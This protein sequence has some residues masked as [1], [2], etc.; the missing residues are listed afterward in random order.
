MRSKPRTS[1]LIV[2]A[3]KPTPTPM[4]IQTSPIRYGSAAHFGEHPL[5]EQ[6]PELAT[7][8]EQGTCVVWFIQNTE[9]EGFSVGNAAVDLRLA[10]DKSR[11]GAK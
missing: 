10:I 9:A 8:K 1:R 11:E 3:T 7:C 5:W 4:F 6:I 2:S